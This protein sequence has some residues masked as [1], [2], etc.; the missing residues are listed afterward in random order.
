MAD[1]QLYQGVSYQQY[2]LT[3]SNSLADF[4]ADLL[5]NMQ[6]SMSQGSGAGNTNQGF[7]LPDIIKAQGELKE[8]MGQMGQSGQEGSKGSEGEGQSGDGEE[9]GE[10][11]E[12]GKEGQG[13][14]GGKD[15]ERGEKGEKG[16]NDG[17]GLGDKGQEGRGQGGKGAT[18][19][20]QGQDGPTEAE[21]K[22]LYE[23]YK[24]Q[25]MLRDQ[26]EEQLRDMINTKDRQL[27]EKLLRQMED[28][29][30]DLLENGVTQRTMNKINTIQHQLLKLE[31]ATLKQGQ[32]QER[33]SNTNTDQFQN[34]ITTRPV[35]LK[36][37]RD[38]IEIL[39]RQTLPLQ[40]I[41]QDKV[42]NYFKKDD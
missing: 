40:Q 20:G 23:I 18:E 16:E 13:K 35:I 12:G 19:S 29:E 31:N 28:F 8:K 6:H 5:D 14:E 25:Q 30:N 33:E 7:Q 27:A 2:V 15:G 32:K 1:S 34:P 37:Y 3:A 38:E 4:L 10:G 17:N 11:N 21:L 22:E 41:F 39:N 26:L 36:D 42:R 9:S 24:E